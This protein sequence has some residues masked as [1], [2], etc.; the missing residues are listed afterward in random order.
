[1]MK[2]INGNYSFDVVEK[3]P[4]GYCVWNIG[5]MQG[6]DEYIPL[7]KADKSCAV[8]IGT[9]KA[10]RLTGHDASKIRRAA[11]IGVKSLSDA[12]KALKSTRHGYISDRKR[13]AAEATI[14]IFQKIS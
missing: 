7:C 8:D 10:I 12:R 13:A 14:D 11:M 6:Q 3:I 5:P 2:I 4:G 9:L 1:M